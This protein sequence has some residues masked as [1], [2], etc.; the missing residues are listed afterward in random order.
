MHDMEHFCF[1]NNG[2]GNVNFSAELHN[3]APHDASFVETIL[4]APL[5]LNIY[6]FVRRIQNYFNYNY[7][8]FVGKY[9]ITCIIFFYKNTN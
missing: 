7:Y 1:T 3:H 9:R 6:G 2:E 8:L 5:D 4:L